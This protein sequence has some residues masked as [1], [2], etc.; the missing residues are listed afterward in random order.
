MDNN[1]V[2]SVS[3][4]EE[5]GP[6][7]D[8]GESPEGDNEGSVSGPEE[9]GPEGDDGESPEGDN[10]GSVSGPEEFG[11][12]G[13]DG[14]S[15]E[16]DSEGSVSGPDAND[17]RTDGEGDLGMNAGNRSTLASN[18]NQLSSTMKVQH[19]KTTA[20]Q[21]KETPPNKKR[22]RMAVSWIGDDSEEDDADSGNVRVKCTIWEPETIKEF[23]STM[24]ESP[25]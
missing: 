12:D 13:D 3:E 7:D 14:E 5:F 1:N 21:E 24:S 9:F 19:R 20:L 16:G 6:D 2:G 10:E 22:K 11:P 15:P 18:L 25:L 17:D 23:V 4:P 8:D